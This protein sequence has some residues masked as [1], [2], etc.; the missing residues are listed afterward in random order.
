MP[1]K[2]LISPVERD[3]AEI[4]KILKKSAAQTEEITK[5]LTAIE[6]AIKQNQEYILALARSTARGSTGL[7]LANMVQTIYH[8]VTGL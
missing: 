7:T 6:K 1:I 8:K 5:R 2:D 3:V 4:K